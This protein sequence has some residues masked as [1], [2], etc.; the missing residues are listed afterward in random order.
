[1]LGAILGG[2]LLNVMPCVFTI[3]SLKTLSLSRQVSEKQAKRGAIAYA[4]SAVFVCVLLGGVIL[5]LRVLGHN[6]RAF[7]LQSPTVM[8][9]L[10]LLMSAVGFNLAGLFEIATLTSGFDLQ[11]KKS[12]HLSNKLASQLPTKASR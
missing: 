3:L 4:L 8:A 1:M 12:P 6:R 9:T 7:Q 5:R 10:I 2:L 11:D